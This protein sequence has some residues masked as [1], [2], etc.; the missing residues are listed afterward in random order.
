MKMKY[1]VCV[2]GGCSLDQTF[3]QKVDGSYNDTPDIVSPGGKGA[4]QAVAAAKAGAKTIILTRVGKD[5]IGKKILDNLNF[6]QV[7]TTNI[8]IEEGLENDYSNIYINLEDKDNNIK[9][10]SGAI[11][12]FTKEMIDKY[13]DI[14]LKSKI[15]VCQLKVPKE[16]TEHLINFCHKHNKLLILTPCRPEKLS[17]TEKGNTDLIDKISIIT[18]NQ[19][20][21]TTI[22]NTD[23]IEACVKKYPNKL[24]VTLGSE[25]LI[26][27]NGKRI[28]KMPAIPTEV[29]DTTGAGDTLNGNLSAFLAKGIDLQHA[30][31]KAMYASAM[32]LTQKTAQAGMPYLEDLEHFIQMQR[33]KKFTYHAELNLALDIIKD[34]YDIVKYTTSFHINTKEDFSLVTDMDLAIEKY[35]INQIKAKFPEDTFVTEEFNSENKLGNRCWIIDPIDGT[36]HFIK[37]ND[38]WG[39][40]LAFYDN[41]SVRF[42]IIYLPIKKELYYAVENVGAFLNN[43][44]ILPKE[45][46]PLNQAIV[47]FGG[48]ICK[49][50]DIKK[51]LLEDFIEKNHLV[52]SNV[53]HINSCC[54][55]YTNLISNKTDALIISSQ[56]PWDIIPGE[57]LC[58]VCDIPIYYLD[59]DKKVRLITNNKEIKKLVLHK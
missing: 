51:L 15:I 50:R 56:K 22:F 32:K 3:F 47:E 59:A 54:I 20:E 43:N 25:G 16:V 36:A 53:L 49:Q 58:K 24:I 42:S 21:C 27:F 8:E 45:E 29:I 44:K 41:D 40:Q 4:N 17:I 14:I 31:R 7:D 39:I 35:L 5:D 37:N 26:Y 9:R 28:I 52:I 18:C 6:Y 30:L 57:F 11:N 2:I 46:V 19:K 1:D 34:A 10:F 38:L 13:Q 12:S 23:D 33:N 55:S 48:S